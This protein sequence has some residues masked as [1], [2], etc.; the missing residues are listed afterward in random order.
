MFQVVFRLV[1][2]AIRWLLR[3]LLVASHTSLPWAQ[4]VASDDVCKSMS[5][6]LFEHANNFRQS[7]GVQ[8]LTWSS[9]L[10][11]SSWN[12][13][14]I[15]SQTGI[16][17]HSIPGQPQMGER[18]ERCGYAFRSIRENIACFD[19][20]GLGHVP[21]AAMVHDGW[22]NSPG[23]RENLLSPDVTE[24]G[25]ATVQDSSGTYWFVQNFGSPRKPHRR[26]PRQSPSR[27]PF[28]AC[29]TTPNPDRAKTF[30][31]FLRQQFKASKPRPRR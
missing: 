29:S 2:R 6:M 27:E 4:A 20:P 12:W 17:A 3:R 8:P 5:H 18:V 15:M 28:P 26:S 13:A 1:W 16:F 24:L 23:H 30:E 14:E 19:Y 22:V 25:V 31:Q 11:L 10:E 7:H 21:L 9:K